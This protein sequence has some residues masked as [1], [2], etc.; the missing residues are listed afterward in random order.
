MTTSDKEQQDM[1]NAKPQAEH[2]WLEK[3]LGDW[4]FEAECNMGPDQPPMKNGGK[5][6]VKSL[7][8]LWIVAEGQ[9]KMPDGDIGLTMM[10]LGYDPKKNRF[11]G[12]WVGS[13]MTHMWIYDG[14]LDA[15][16]KILT[17]TAEGPSFTDP[18]KMTK[19]QDIIEI[20][21]DNER[22]LRS[23][24]LGEDGK[25]SD[26]FMTAVYKRKA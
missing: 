22:T 3:L 6:S 23:R 25:W 11:I 21:N 20:K 1:C 7:D 14:E 15:S 9:G 26:Y 13:M 18:S 16:G 24:F 2:K 17:L 12:T 4:T 5:E 19:Y 8:G 10:T